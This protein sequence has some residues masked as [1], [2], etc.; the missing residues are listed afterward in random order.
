[1]KEI[2]NILEVYD[3]T[4]FSERK[5]V[6]ATVVKVQGSSYRNPGARMLI[7]DNARWVGSISGG[8]LEGDAM[9]KAKVV[10]RDKK[11][12]FLTY[13][14]MDDENN[15]L[16]IGLGCN[17]IIDV[18]ME[19]VDPS[20]ANNPVE[21]LR[22]LPSIKDLTAMALVYQSEHEKCEV[23]ARCFFADKQEQELRDLVED[24]LAASL[25]EKR[26]KVQSYEVDGQKVEVLL[27]VIEP[28]IEL[29]IFGGGFDAK[30]VTQLAKAL[31][32]KVRVSDECIAHIAPSNFPAA[33]EVV[34]CQREYVHR[35]VEVSPY[36]AIVLMSHNYHYDLE[37]LK[38]VKDTAAPYIGILGP[39]KRTDK[40][41]AE[42]EKQNIQLTSRDL[43]RIHTP[44][45]LDI[46]AESPEE[47]ALAIL[48]EVL[49]KFSGRSGG[50]LKYHKGP[51]HKREGVNDLVF[52]QLYLSSS[53]Q[54]D[55]QEIG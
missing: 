52:K 12:M 39:K 9:R 54:E 34:A 31:G 13:D 37:V 24:D 48:G 27:E 51:I 4:D 14:T 7:L 18:L 21:K 49:A 25:D 46:G 33:D 17:G 20:D 8:C 50:H 2:Q 35:D 42:L 41:F 1:M 26:S 28:A 55:V 32:W 22:E 47:I 40:L 36:T 11:P 43:E 30:P 38:Q 15:T 5:A 10:M 23:G 19:A 6:L 3:Q 16:G 53:D 45:G 29:L 44:I